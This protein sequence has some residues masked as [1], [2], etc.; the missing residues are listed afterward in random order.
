[1]SVEVP[2][3]RARIA[4]LLWPGVDEQ[5]ARANLRQRLAKLRELDSGLLQDDG[6]LLALAQGV[7]VDTGAGALL[8]SFDYGDCEVFAQWL[9]GQRDAVQAGQRRFLFEQAR[10]AIEA[11]ELGRAQSGAEAALALDRESEDAHRLLMEVLY[12]R[13][14]YAE[15]ITVWDR[16]RDMLRQIY[17]V[18]PS[19]AT[20]ALGELALQAAHAGRAATVPARDVMPLSLLRPPQMI[21][22]S[23]ALDTL[24]AAWY[25]GQVL[26]VSGAAGLGKSRLLA[27]F[28]GAAGG[29]ASVAARPGDA[30]QPYAAL[31]RLLLAAIDRTEPAPDPTLLHQAARLVPALVPAL[32]RAAGAAPEPLRTAH[33]RTRALQAVCR[34]LQD[35]ATRGCETFVF[36]DLHFADRASV[37]ALPVLLAVT[38]PALRFA[39][40]TRSGEETLAGSAMLDSLAAQGRLTRL[41]LEVLGQAEVS[42]LLASL[43]LPGIDAEALAP[44][45]RRRVGGN[46]AFLLESLKLLLSLGTDALARPDLLPLAPGI[47]A[48]VARRIDLLTVSARQ[49]AQLAAVAGPAFSPALAGKVLGCSAAELVAPMRELE[50]RQVLYGRRFVHDLVANAV[51]NTTTPADAEQLHRGVAEALNAQGDEPARIAG[52]WRACGE[53]QRAGLCYR[54]AAEA[55]RQA[56]RT[57]ERTEL[58]DA[59]AECLERAGAQAELFDTLE[60][61][62]NVSDAP[63]RAQRR[64]PLMVRLE[65]MAQTPEQ[66]LRALAQRVGWHAD[67][68][69]PEG[70]ELGRQGMRRA[71]ALGLPELAF[72]FVNGVAWHLAISGQSSA[73]VQALEL[74]RGWVQTQPPV[75]QAEFHLI[76]SGVQ[77]FCDHLLPAIA[78]AEDALALL[79]S[80]GRQ[81]RTLPVLS[82][83]GVFRWTRGEFD[84]AKAA[85]LEA[86][87]LRDRMHGGGASLTID[88]ILGAVL[89]DRGEYL[90]AHETLTTVLDRYRQMALAQGAAADQTDVFLAENHLAEFWLRIGRPL[91][92]QACLC[93]PAGTGFDPRFVAR[94]GVLQLRI[95][96]ALG[97][98]E[99]LLLEQT[100]QR[101]ATIGSAYFRAWIELDLTRSLAPDEAVLEFERLAKCAPVRERPGLQLHAALRVAQ[102]AQSCGRGAAALEWLDQAL[103]LAERYEPFDIDRAELWLTACQLLTAAGQVA[104]ACRWRDIGAEWLQRTAARQMTSA[105]RESFLHA[106][107]VHRA[108][109]DAAAPRGGTAKPT[110][111]P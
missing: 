15:A 99:P 65:T 28:C 44:A 18:P 6:R 98:A 57:V 88:M 4:T 20:R 102:A 90:A 76:L 59:A 17:G 12:L 36:D 26:C 8:A 47:D 56:L 23:R 11:G 42:T 72:G 94:R 73:A 2:T 55:A 25:A 49:V 19:P 54:D 85:L 3:P 34:L 35:C 69:R 61:R 38:A 7:T 13:G 87:A 37:E 106:H 100:R 74:H 71:L 53:W 89:R 77:S 82:N 62:L 78:S 32:T 60:Q 48:V 110:V 10:S 64:V 70:F 31:G 108:L 79:R 39:M 91:D 1:M 40:G 75:T 50:Q 109:L 93:A 46:P 51:L 5:R 86:L 81:E 58:L 41:E 67:N 14:A 105:W 27:E 107:P 21:G 97:H 22:R 103:V 68:T 66:E 43:A 101:V 30:L 95:S 9:E 92:A 83:I 104:A 16:C 33:E 63:D 45:L 24:L 111:A 29:G 52:H 84:A 80:A 96:R